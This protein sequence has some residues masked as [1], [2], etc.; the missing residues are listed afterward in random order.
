MFLAKKINNNNLTNKKY[1][2][3]EKSL[4]VEETGFYID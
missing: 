2:K 4:S 1:E 3:N